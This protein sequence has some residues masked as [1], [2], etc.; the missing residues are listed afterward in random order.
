MALSAGVVT[1]GGAKLSGPL[2]RWR[3]L[4]APDADEGSRGVLGGGAMG[5]DDGGA[6][7]GATVRW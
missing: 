4:N 2:S 6:W 5:S 7:V 1:G 3:L